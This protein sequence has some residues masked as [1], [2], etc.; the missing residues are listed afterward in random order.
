M[1]LRNKCGRS[2]VDIALVCTPITAFGFAAVAKPL[3]G[4]ALQPKFELDKG[5]ASPLAKDADAFHAGVQISQE[6]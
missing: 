3:F 2:V 4:P 1:K 6:R 5:L